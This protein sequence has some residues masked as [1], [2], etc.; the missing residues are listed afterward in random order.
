MC[1]IAGYIS[2]NKAIDKSLLEGITDVIAHRGPDAAG[3][4]TDHHVALGHRRLSIL[5][6]S[7]AANQ[8]MESACGNYVI[9]FN[10]EV[11]N[12]RE[13]V[14]QLDISLKTTSDTEVILEAY[15]K[16]GKSCV[17]MFNGMFSFVI[18]NK[19][20]HELF[21]CRDRMGIKPLF[22]YFDGQT[23]A[24]ASE[25]KSLIKLY[26]EKKTL[27]H[28]AIYR[29]LHLNYIPAPDT[30][31]EAFKKFPS[32]HSA[33][34]KNGELQFDCYWNLE[35]KISSQVWTDEYSAK[36][37]LKTLLEK[38][39]AY[40]MISDVPFGT[41]LSG[42]IDSSIVTAVAQSLSETPVNTF[43]I[44]FENAKYNE[45]VY[46][47]SVAK[48]LGTKHHELVL[49]EKDA[50]DLFSRIFDAYDE[51]FADAS[52][53]STMLVTKFSREQVT[54]TVS[55]D[56]GDE[57]FMGYGFYKWRQRLSN[58]LVTM[59]RPFIQALLSFGDE[60]MKRA[61]W[62]FDKVRKD[63]L[64]SHIF[65]QESYN[66]SKRELGKLHL[67]SSEK[68]AL[69]EKHHTINRKLSVREQQALFDLKYYL[70]DDLLVKVDRA[71]MQFSLETRVPLLDYNIVEFALNLDESL[72]IRNGETK[73]LLKQVLYD[74]LPKELFDRPKWGFGIP[75]NKWL[76]KELFHLQERY[77]SR[78]VT[79][80]HGILNYDELV[81][82]QRKYNSGMD[83]YVNRVWLPIVLHAFLEK[84]H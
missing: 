77:L 51:P 37:Q 57:L 47:Q 33:T 13:L 58:P 71:T 9:V 64:A 24:F 26:P 46:S 12:Y 32:G 45:S 53:I 21:I 14:P 10:G 36:K 67:K 55:G 73:Y 1:G 8:P 80:K 29:F 72:K 78:E 28:Q 66:F 40:R 79:E 38:S 16:F 25:L 4:F 82:Y 84:H 49:K 70:Q 68:F 43:S 81:K 11:Y 15:V 2:T 54:M 7:D 18:Y 22:Y 62:L 74:Y 41:F 83:T 30:I 50:L 6:L 35:E 39:V 56:G 76:R 20:N 59:A 63:E 3:Y 61:S 27:N 65:S 17:N 5:D 31:Y 19:G 60:R 44:A 23:F 69:L 48:K 52:A 75:L 42:G 34:F